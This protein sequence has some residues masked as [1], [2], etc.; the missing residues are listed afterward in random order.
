[1]PLFNPVKTLQQTHSASWT[2]LISPLWCL[3]QASASWRQLEI[4]VEVANVKIPDGHLGLQDILLWFKTGQ[5]IFLA[6]LW[7]VVSKF[8]YRPPSKIKMK[9]TTDISN[10]CLPLCKRTSSYFY[11]SNPINPLHYQPFPSAAE[12]YVVLKVRNQ[13]HYVEKVR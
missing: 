7:I 3:Q 5:V 11:R 10:P 4:L 13:C 2:P 6:P 1:M 9:R 12:S 8:Q